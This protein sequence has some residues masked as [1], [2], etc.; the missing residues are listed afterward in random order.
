MF[1]SDGEAERARLLAQ[2]Q[3]GGLGRQEVDVRRERP[4]QVQDVVPAV[5]ADD[6]LA[7]DGRAEFHLLTLVVDD[8]VSGDLQLLA[9]LAEL[10]GEGRVIGG[11][12]AD[13]AVNVSHRGTSWWAKNNNRN[14][15][16]YRE[17][18]MVQTTPS[19]IT[20]A[21]NVQ[22]ACI[23]YTSLPSNQTT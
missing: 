5:V 15:L 19:D 22:Y 10:W 16:S 23:I 6:A 7:L 17:T 21:K 8:F 9:R 4:Q 13:D 3:L 2:L 18:C 20:A 14:D 12:P 11:M 1:V